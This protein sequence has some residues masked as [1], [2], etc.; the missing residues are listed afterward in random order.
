MLQNLTLFE[1]RRRNFFVRHCLLLL[2]DQ[3]HGLTANPQFESDIAGVL[4]AIS[5]VVLDLVGRGKGHVV[6]VVL[7]SQRVRLCFFL[8]NVE[9]AIHVERVGVDRA[10]G[11]FLD[12]LLLT[13][14]RRALEP[15]TADVGFVRG[16]R[17]FKVTPC[18]TS[19]LLYPVALHERWLIPNAA[20]H[21][22]RF[23]R[24][25]LVLGLQKF[26]LV[27]FLASSTSELWA[28]FG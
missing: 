11:T 18:L 7:L 24:V 25:L 8:S 17:T 22:L 16:V 5:L 12:R 26:Y 3:K 10:A 1:L 20:R 6:T 9:R 28:F 15:R 2:C 21:F 13:C 14:H 4:T 27:F 19:P 23:R